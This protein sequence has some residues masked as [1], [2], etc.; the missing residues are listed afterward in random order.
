ML[1]NASRHRVGR[2]FAV[3]VIGAWIGATAAPAAAT[4]LT[5]TPAGSTVPGVGPVGIDAMPTRSG[6][7]VIVGDHQGDT[8]RSLQHDRTT[9]GLRPASSVPLDGPSAVR[10]ALEGRY[11]VVSSLPSNEVISYSVDRRTGA[12]TL[13]SRAPSGGTGPVALDVSTEGFVVVANKDSDNLGVLTIN[14]K[15]F[16]DAVGTMPVGD[17]PAGV[18]IDHGNVLVPHANSF[19]VHQLRLDRF[20]ALHPIGTAALG[21]RVSSVA[22]VAPDI[23]VASTY[24]NGDLHAFRV[25]RTGL[26]ALGTTPSGAD[27]MY[28][29]MDPRGFLHAVGSTRLASFEVSAK[30]GGATEVATLP[31]TGLSSRTLVAVA[32]GTSASDVV[33]NEYNGNATF[34]VRASAAAQ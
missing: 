27:V 1:T 26:D 25:E 6:G 18:R 31:L 13:R 32:A 20:G 2:V 12:M 19:D 21:A 5:L 16:L 29:T 9:G 22:F 34:V 8:V 10:F 3:L 15:G 23:A 11:A 4:P 17:G 30:T 14:P 24:P 33:V 7:L 28:L